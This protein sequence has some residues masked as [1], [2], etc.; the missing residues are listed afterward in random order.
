MSLQEL[1]AVKI[2][3]QQQDQR[4]TTEATESNVPVTSPLD[5]K[6]HFNFDYIYVKFDGYLNGSQELTPQQVLWAG[7]PNPR[8]NDQYPVVPTTIEQQVLS[9]ELSYDI[10]DDVSVSL[11]IPYIHQST[12]HI[13]IVPGFSDFNITSQGLGDISTGVS[14]QA[15][16]SDSG[17]LLVAGDLSY[18]TGSIN[19]QG[20]TPRSATMD[21]QL[22]Y[23]MQLGSGTVDFTPAIAYVGWN[24]SWLWG[25]GA[26]ATIRFGENYRGYRLGNIYEVEGWVR[27]VES[28]WVQPSFRLTT[29]FWD[30][31]HGQDSELLAPA[32]PT[33]P[34]PAPVTNPNAFGGTKIL[35]LPGIRLSYPKGWFRGQYIEVE[36]GVPVYQYLNGPQPKEDWR[37]NVS[38]TLNF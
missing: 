12:E 37:I 18:P 2:V 25:V 24:D 7:P 5:R 11:Y 20:R 35:A 32:L 22:P 31:I 27:Y 3:R 15:I 13:S 36:G 16:T 26:D 29:I 19:E 34:Y 9:F 10:S 14:W 38:L 28:S 30:Q 23:T 8:P 1:L 17:T 4:T 21:T 33:N 6:F